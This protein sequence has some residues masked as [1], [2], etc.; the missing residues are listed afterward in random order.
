MEANGCGR[1][2]SEHSSFEHTQKKSRMFVGTANAPYATPIFRGR[3]NT[4]NFKNLRIHHH[5]NLRASLFNV[6]HQHSS[7]LRCN[8]V[9]LLLINQGTHAIQEWQN[10]SSDKTETRQTFASGVTV[11]NVRKNGLTKIIAPLPPYNIH[12]DA[13]KNN[14]RHDLGQIMD[15]YIADVPPSR[16]QADKHTHKVFNQSNKQT[17]K[18]WICTLALLLS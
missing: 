17:K 4:P 6:E 14:G 7:M 2:P 18:R 9:D 16:A 15:I 3:V 5:W 12:D 11:C 8:T 13:M 1:T 10:V